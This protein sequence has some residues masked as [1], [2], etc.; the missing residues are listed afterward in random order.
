[1]KTLYK[2]L[3]SLLLIISTS[4]LA[5]FKTIDRGANS[6][7][8]NTSYWLIFAARDYAPGHA[9]I[10]W[11]IKDRSTNQWT[12]LLG[13]GLYPQNSSKAA[14]GT[15]PGHIVKETANS[16]SAAN[17]GLVVSVTKQMYDYVLMNTEAIRNGV[18]PYHFINESCVDFTEL[19]ARA[20]GLNT[21]NKEHLTNY[22]QAFISELRDLNN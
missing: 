18:V 5:D 14:F 4:V 21:P 16:L 10:I 8:T 19:A 1:M 15:V 20:I 2:L 12:S 22:P 13:Y 9:F 7:S 6:W 11:G 17:N 3:L